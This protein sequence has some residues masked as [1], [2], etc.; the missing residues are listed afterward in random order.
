MAP[1][2][3]MDAADEARPGWSLAA[4]L[5]GW[6]D[7]AG[8]TGGRMTSRCL[9]TLA[10]LWLLGSTAVTG[11]SPQR[12]GAEPNPDE[13]AIRSLIATYVKSVDTADTTLASTV[14]ATTPDVSFIHP[15]GHEH[16]WPAIKTKFY[17]QTMGESFS[18][19]RLSV[20]DI[21]LSTY[22]DTA[23]AEFYWDFVAKLRKDGTPISTQ[24]RETQV[25]RKID[26]AWRLI[27]V[28]YSGMP[29]T[30]ERK[31]F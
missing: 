7:D 16:G 29:V 10:V 22:G 15:R 11:D 28:H 8:R 31:G 21:A 4:D 5:S 9:V 12:A 27:H 19:R 20:K 18:E 25:Y 24:G 17:E 2:E 14:W 3:Q 6:A 30:G 23:W 1:V 13:G 26:G